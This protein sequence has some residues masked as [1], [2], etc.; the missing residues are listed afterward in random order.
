MNIWH[1][2]IHPDDKDQAEAWGRQALKESCIALDIG[3]D[4]TNGK[5]FE[6]W[7]D[8]DFEK[9]IELHKTHYGKTGVSS[10]LKS[11]YNDMQIDDI[12]LL[13]AGGEPLA[14]VKIGKYFFEPNPKSIMSFRHRRKIDI[15]DW[16]DNI[17]NKIPGFKINPPSQGTLSILLPKNQTHTYKNILK[18]YEYLQEEAKMK[19]MIDQLI[20]NK[21]IILTG[22]PGTGK[23]YLAK[24]IA[25]NITEDNSIQHNF[26]Q[27]HPS[28]DY[29]DFVEGLKPHMPSDSK[30]IQFELKN[31]IFKEFCRVAG[32]I[33]RIN[34][35][36]KMNA[37]K[38]NLNEFLPDNEP[39]VTFWNE[40]LDNNSDLAKNSMSD[41]IINELP[42]FV[43]IIDEIN[44]AELSRVFGEL[45]FAIEPGYRGSNGKI[46]T[47]YAS[48]I[49]DK[50][51]FVNKDDD[52][53]F[54]PSNVY[55][56]GTMNDIDRSVEVF[57]F[58]I[59]RRFSWHEIKAD[60]E[61][62]NQVLNSLD[63]IDEKI[64]EETKKR[65]KNLNEKISNIPGL[66]ASYHIGPAYYIKIKDYNDD[67]RWQSIWDYHLRPLL[68]EYLRGRPNIEELMK[69]LEEEFFQ[70]ESTS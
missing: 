31:G 27:F 10:Q 47:Q 19:K 49:T 52:Y 22:P 69:G 40:W 13:R 45:F 24:E 32:V 68:R 18:W 3:Y 9:C 7:S 42:K 5:S 28:Y 30:D 48:M 34:C 15:L 8:D 29:T 20:S 16:Y 25:K 44:R 57:D 41:N 17:I 38:N 62:F 60:D 53:F 39:A 6:F 1:M 66:N 61:N 64:L 12:L 14:L 65:A 2:Q 59:R 36:N 54:V 63:R 23:T 58:A 26:V 4:P 67:N 35:A 46:K 11:F 37:I 43:F 70:N 21:Q 51:F 33:E 55:I 50:T 56:I